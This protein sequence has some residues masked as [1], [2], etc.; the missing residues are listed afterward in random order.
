MRKFSLIIFLL[1]APVALAGCFNLAKYD[2]TVIEKNQELSDTAKEKVEQGIEVGK[3]KLKEYTKAQL[4]KISSGLTESA[5]QAIDEWLSEKGLN[6]YGDPQGTMYAGGTPLF[7]EASGK[8]KDKYEYILEKHPE[9][10]K[11]LGL[12]E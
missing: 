8:T 10:I 12:E 9:L 2:Q 4:E 3:E 11:E 5:K 7:D 6:K 1:L